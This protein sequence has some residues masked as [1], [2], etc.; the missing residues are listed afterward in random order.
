[1]KI[2]NL[3][4][5]SFLLF[6]NKSSFGQSV[7]LIKEGII[8][9]DKTI[10]KYALIERSIKT[11]NSSNLVLEEFARYKREH[12]QFLTL[13]S[14]LTFSSNRTMFEPTNYVDDNNENFWN[15]KIIS[16]QFNT[17]FNDFSN[18]TTF[19]EKKILGNNFLIV[20]SLRNITWKITD[21]TRN[22]AGFKC[23]RANGLVMDS[24]YVVAFYTNE[25]PIASGPESFSG[26]PGMILGLAIPSE[27]VNWFATKII[28]KP[29]SIPLWSTKP[30]K[31]FTYKQLEAVLADTFKNYGSA[32]QSILRNFLL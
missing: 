27:N 6:I 2:I 24:I 3:I 11:I 15:G 32:L 12:T 28:Q 31:Q 9:F 8:Q 23:R 22:I 16:D 25:I 13:K 21:E 18:N 10:N 4:L 5:L 29:V 19:I 30:T 17:V 14:T 26:L 1:M 7:H 20:D